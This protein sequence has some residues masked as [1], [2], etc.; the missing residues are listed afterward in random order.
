LYGVDQILPAN[1]DAREREN[2]H[3]V[4]EQFMNN[5]IGQ[6]FRRDDVRETVIP[7]YM[8]LIKQCDDQLGRLLDH[9]E[10]TGRMKDTMIILTSDH[11][12]YLGD[13]WLG[14]KD[15]FHAESVKVPLI[16]YD[17]SQAADT[18]RGTTCEALIESIDVAATCIEVQGGEV[19]KHIVEGRSFLPF[20]RGEKPTN[21]RSFVVSEYD[22]SATSM[23]ANLELAPTDA[24]IFMIATQNWK[25]MH[26]EGGFR[27]MLFDLESDP[28]ELNDLGDSDS[29]TA[30]I[31]LLYDHL[32][33]W[34][35]RSSQ[36]TTISDGEILRHRSG[37]GSESK[38]I[39]IGA[40]SDDDT[41]P[42]N[43]S[44]YVGKASP[45]P[46]R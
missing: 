45:I 6:A 27:P 10:S 46:K 12:D 30:I 19:P 29:H 23:A 13:H 2:P 35:R 44:R 26:F 14:E 17:P 37:G 41:T 3:P 9:L 31:D 5:K 39:L 18:T 33:S 7:A 38:G 11:G 25:L 42:Q 8:G 22:Y 40:Y 16:V 1:R 15:L 34:A 20:L 32:F 4:Y 36:R 43:L 21:W 24:R 28:N